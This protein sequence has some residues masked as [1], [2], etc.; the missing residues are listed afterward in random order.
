PWRW[1][2]VLI[3][4]APYLLF[5]VART[6]MDPGSP[7]AAAS[8]MR[9][10]LLTLL[11]QVWTLVVP[12]WIARSRKAPMP[13]LPR[14]RAVFIE[15]LFAL[16]VLP[17][18][19]GAMMAVFSIM[20]S[21]FGGTASPSGPWAPLTGSFDGFEWLAFIAMAVT[22]APVAEE[23]FHRGLLYNLLRQ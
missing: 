3:S 20:A 17:A 6:F 13:R 5:R 7:L 11:T 4:L 1:S 15:A 21:L 9:F 12:L 16:L 2:D 14:P 18:V 10:L 19:F 8:G 23:V 22:L